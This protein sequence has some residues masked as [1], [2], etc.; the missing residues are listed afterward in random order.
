MPI[1]SLKQ[2]QKQSMPFLAKDCWF[3]A[4]ME[5]EDPERISFHRHTKITTTYRREFMQ[6]NNQQITQL[7]N[8]QKTWI[9]IFPKKTY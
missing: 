6:L 7:K 5:W 4:K 1:T 8:E 3:V 2:K 9:D